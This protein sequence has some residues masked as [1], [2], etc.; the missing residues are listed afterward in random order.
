MRFLKKNGDARS[1]IGMLAGVQRRFSESEPELM[2]LPNPDEAALRSDLENLSRINRVFGAKGKLEQIFRRLAGSIRKMTVIDLASGYGDHGR[3]LIRSGRTRGQE[4][5]VVAVDY[6]LSTLR[7]AREATGPD[8]KI[9][10]VQA[11]ARQLP[12]RRRSGDFVF[13][14][15]ALHHFSEADAQ[16]VLSEMARVARRGMACL[17]LAR[18]RLAD[19]AIMLLTTFII[20][21]P[22]VIHDARLSSRRAFAPAE[23]RAMAQAAKWPSL[24]HATFPWFQQ[25]V[26][27]RPTS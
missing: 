12:F 2:D 26:I 17:D 22:M 5:T 10:F 16:Q 3:N 24:R 23:L 27:G 1:T 13:C 15:L 8:Q 21:D 6:Q 9:F 25:A 11:D 20:R 18:S 14:T 19:F 7:I 4:V